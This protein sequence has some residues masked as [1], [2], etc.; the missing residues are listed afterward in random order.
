MHEYKEASKAYQ[1][2]KNTDL[3]GVEKCIQQMEQGKFDWDLHYHLMALI[4]L[5]GAADERVSMQ[6]IN[7]GTFKRHYDAGCPKDDPNLK[8]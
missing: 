3:K 6:Q 5:W 8:G 7:D 2:R 1:K 4:H